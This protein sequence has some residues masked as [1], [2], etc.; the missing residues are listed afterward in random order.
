MLETGE[1]DVLVLSKV[2]I[3]AQLRWQNAQNEDLPINR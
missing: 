1:I 2:D 3:L